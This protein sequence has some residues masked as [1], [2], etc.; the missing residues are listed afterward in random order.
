M[1]AIQFL[2]E[3]A[4]ALVAF[5]I[6]LSL[7]LFVA[8]DL[9][10]GGG[11]QSRRIRKYYEI[12]E[13]A[14]EKISYQDFETRV[15]GLVEIYKL[16]GTD[17]TAEMY[18]TV[19]DNVWDQ[20]VREKIL[21]SKYDKLGIGVSNDELD[22]LVLGDNPHPIVLQL[23]TDRT[24][25][26]FNQSYLVNFLKQIEL[27]ETVRTYWLFF[28]DEIV[29][30]RA[31]TKYNT[32]VSKGLYVTSKM[33][34]FQRALNGPTV[35]FSY[36]MKNYASIPDTAITISTG[37]IKDYYKKHREDYKRTAS[38]DIEYVTFDVV[39]SE[40]DRKSIEA[41]LTD[42]IEA[43][44]TATDPEQYINLTSDTRFNGFYQT[45]DQ[46]APAL[47][48]FVGGGD[49]DA[50]YGPY[51]EEGYFKIAKILDIANRPDS[52]HAR[53]ILISSGTSYESVKA[54]AD[55]LASV[56]RSDKASF[57][58]LAIAYSEDQG[59]AAVGGDL[60]WFEEGMMV[61]SFNDACFSGK[62]GDVVVTESNYGF[63]IIEI[64]DQSRNVRKYKIGEID[65]QIEPSSA[66]IQDVYS[67]AS[68]FIGNYNTYDRFNEGIAELGMSKKI[69]NSVSPDQASLPGLDDSRNLVM[70]LFNSKE[71]GS[72][73]LDNS[74]Q[75][76][77]EVGDKYVVGF[78]TRIQKE[79]YAP[80]EDVRPDII[81]A[82]TIEKKAE[83]LIEDFNSI[84]AGS[85]TID[86]LATNMG[87]TVQDA[88]QINF[89]SYYVSGIAGNEPALIAAATVA[90]E[91]VTTGPIKGNN[92]VFMLAVYNS[93]D[94]SS[95]QDPD[96]LRMN[97]SYTYG[98]R[99]SYG[100]YEALQSAA[101]IVDQRYKFY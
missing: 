67:Q 23:F 97:L 37:E 83:R 93:V 77:L 49:T 87:L 66:T 39:P 21:D 55:S 71:E 35:D 73:V 47:R 75:A 34:E 95:E 25:G 91:G 68:S 7:I 28:E 45:I 33:V 98:M 4:G 88:A 58:P 86:N 50:V 1:S 27:D 24:T 40:E 18:E 22:D 11:S 42:N 46:V 70:S 84:N 96:M 59:S 44:K 78:C 13:I 101:N 31:S 90:P 14:G 69:A 99:G 48:E 12:G 74:E 19:R 17:V 16:S 38:R 8:S 82:L 62:K 61:T 64:L 92:G 76:V 53:H 26:V 36:V 2:R 43:F 63:H 30:E 41:W 80:I 3:K 29:N 60:G 89:S 56:I 85:M 5:V 20:M 15:Q 52:V 54:M 32:L 72:A 9:V 6:G 100:A 57:E 51:E 81:F 94:S 65:R 79:G 10:G